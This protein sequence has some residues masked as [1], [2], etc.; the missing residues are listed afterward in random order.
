MGR[1]VVV[2]PLIVTVVSLMSFYCCFK[3]EYVLLTVVTHPEPGCVVGW[4][5]ILI[6]NFKNKR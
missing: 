2:M 6:I 3:V 5:R 4:P 1:N